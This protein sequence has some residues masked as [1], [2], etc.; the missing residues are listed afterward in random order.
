[1]VHARISRE[2]NRLSVID[3][4]CRP[5]DREANNQTT[6]KLEKLTKEINLLTGTSL[7]RV[8][9]RFCLFVPTAA[10]SAS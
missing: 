5:T 7:A 1:M 2:K 8:G 9:L 3:P 10:V 4:E 6:K